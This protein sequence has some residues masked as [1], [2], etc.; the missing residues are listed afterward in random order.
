MVRPIEISD[1]LT[2]AE[3]VQRLQQNQKVQPEAAQ[4]FQKTITGKLI[5]QVKTPNPVPQ[6]DQV[7]L[8]V[9]EQEKEKRKT[10]EDDQQSSPEQNEE[11]DQGQEEQKDEKKSLSADQSDHID[12]T[13]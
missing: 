11:P 7:V 5:E 12:I 4:Q 10:A 8:H 2:K 3:A 1:S 6:G 13:A 9:D